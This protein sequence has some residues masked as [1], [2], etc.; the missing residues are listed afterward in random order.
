MTA[1]HAV[2]TR[3]PD[4]IVRSTDA[5]GGGDSVAAWVADELLARGV[6]ADS[7]SVVTSDSGSRE[8]L[9]FWSSARD[10][11]LMFAN[12]GV[13]PWTLTNSATGR[14]S[15]VLGI[16]GACTTFVGGAEELERVLR[17]AEDAV[18]DGISAAVLVVT[19]DGVDAPDASGRSSRI[20]LAAYLVQR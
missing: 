1:R 14:I 13:F 9:A 15:Q 8:A 10:T 19:I 18:A 6:R 7:L 3:R 20:A 4:F 12:P 17:D 11:G 16:H 5:V 2:G